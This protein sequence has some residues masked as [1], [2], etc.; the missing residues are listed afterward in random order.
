VPF[1]SMRVF[2]V[3]HHLQIDKTRKRAK[4]VHG[5]FDTQFLTMLLC[6]YFVAKDRDEQRDIP[7]TTL[8]G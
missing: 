6:R 1:F 7:G 4:I 3:A 8:F 2:V 5:V